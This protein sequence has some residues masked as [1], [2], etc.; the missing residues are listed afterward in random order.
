VLQVSM[1]RSFSCHNLLGPGGSD[2][3]LNVASSILHLAGHRSIGDY[4]FPQY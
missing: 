3:S 4:I 1:H 2:N